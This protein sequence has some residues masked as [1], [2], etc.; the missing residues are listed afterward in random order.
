MALGTWAFPNRTVMSLCSSAPTPSA[1]WPGSLRGTLSWRG[2]AG[3]VRVRS[4]PWPCRG[5]GAR[6]SLAPGSRGVP[7]LALRLTQGLV[8]RASTEG[9]WFRALPRSSAVPAPSQK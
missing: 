5:V 4:I 3:R 1:R 6:E 8:L 7:L 2:G 9:K